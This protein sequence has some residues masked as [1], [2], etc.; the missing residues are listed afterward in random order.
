MTTEPWCFLHAADLHID[1]PMRGLVAYEG[2]PVEALRLATRDAFRALIELAIER[3]VRF[4]LL[5]GD[6][7]DGDWPDFESRLWFIDKL[8]SL[9]AAGIEVFA[10]RGN[11]DAESRMTQELRWPEGV[12]VFDAKAPGSVEVAGL[13][14]VVHGQSYADPKTTLNLAQGYPDPAPGKLNIGML[15]TAL[16]G[17]A[18]HGTYAPCTVADLTAK[19]YDY[20]ALGHVH[21][22]EVVSEDPWIVFPGNLQGRHVRETGAKGASIV[23]VR[24]GLIQGVEHVD[25][26]VA[27]WQVVSVDA[28]GA[29]EEDE[30]LTRVEARLRAALQEGGGR[31]VAARLQV[32]GTTTLDAQLRLD[33]VRW[34]QEVRASAA[35]VSTELWLEK[36]E[37]R[38][39]AEGSSEEPGPVHGGLAGLGQRI[40]KAELDDEELA[41]L[42][43]RMAKLSGRLPAEVRE[44]H[45]PGDRQVLA[46]ALEPARRYLAAMLSAGDGSQAGEGE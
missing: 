2:A 44:A 4:V 3:R 6:L 9:T 33:E 15:H 28:T 1:S 8:R 29:M 21:A 40:A 7:F 42:T 30:L 37:L 11:H 24:D 23:E 25:C 22:R 46:A 35:R 36:V 26:D 18:G 27:R 5:A 17:R 13:E 31:L 20:W 43:Q 45:D 41:A 12:H 39:G 16:E 10:V 34:T 38:T 14:A 32:T 19:G